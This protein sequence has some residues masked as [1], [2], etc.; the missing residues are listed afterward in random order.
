MTPNGNTHTNTL[1]TTTHPV[2]RRTIDKQTATT[3]TQTLRARR[4]KQTH[5]RKQHERR[6]TK[7]GTI[8]IMRTIIRTASV[9]A[10][11]S[12]RAEQRIRTLIKDM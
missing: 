11:I 7:T 1:K 3:T 5:Q 8:S 9:S 12:T 10:L 2:P 4:R 6:H